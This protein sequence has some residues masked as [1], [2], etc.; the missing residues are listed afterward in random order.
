M[1]ERWRRFREGSITSQVIA[2]LIAAAILTTIGWLV[3]VLPGIATGLI[4]AIYLGYLLLL[5]SVPVPAWGLLLIV[6]G[7]LWLVRRYSKRLGA[8]KAQLAA[9]DEA[10]KQLEA[11]YAPTEKPVSPDFKPTDN[12]RR[13][14]TYLLHEFPTKKR[15]DE[16]HLYTRCANPA[17]TAKEL[18]GLIAAH[19]MNR[20]GT[21][22][23]FYGLTVPGCDAALQWCDGMTPHSRK[24]EP[25]LR[26]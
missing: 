22:Y 7:A 24:Q 20:E 9:A 8:S 18:D 26:I 6:S 15:L 11:K 3:S 12:Q 14:L 19:V 17:L 25:R 5:K 13:A 23:E 2:A 16:L 4:F 1:W 10:L 21:T